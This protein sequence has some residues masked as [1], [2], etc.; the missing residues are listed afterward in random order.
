VDT[1]KYTTGID[2][3]SSKWYNICY[4]AQQLTQQQELFC[5]LY[6]T[7]GT[8]FDNATL[9]YAEAYSYEI[10]KDEKGKNIVESK[11]YN[12][13]S[14]NASRLI[15]NDKI[16][17]RIRDLF[18]ELLNEATM[19]ARLSEIATKGKD[20]DSIQA[21]KIFNDLRQRI[22]RKVDITT[23]GRPLANLSDEE[24]QTLAE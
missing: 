10:P 15:S 8:Y 22:T 18:L 4:M 13:C 16:R 24:L 11:E 7:K 1:E 6:T 9:S 14:A 17:D 23:G 5:K 12:I 19:D 20:T 3:M 2:S 21:I